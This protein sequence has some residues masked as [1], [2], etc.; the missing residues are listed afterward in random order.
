MRRREFITLLGGAAAAWPMA[1]RAQQPERMRRMGVFM[2]LASDD[3]D[4]QA[5]I[6][7]LL[8]GLQQYGWTIGGNLRVDYRWNVGD[9]DGFRRYAADLVAPAPDVI[10]TVAGAALAALQQATRII[11][12]VFVGAI[13]P[14]GAGVVASLARP[15]GNATGFTLYE[16]GLSGKWLELLKQFVP[17]ITRAGILRDSTTTGGVGQFAALQAVAPS[18]G[19]ELSP[20]DVRDA[21]EIERAVT[22]FAREP[23][24]ALVVTLSGLAISHRELIVILAARHR[25]PAVYAYRPF[26]TGGGLISYGP[27]I[28]DQYRRAAG[29][30]DRILKG[31]KP[32]DL[33]VQAPTKYELMINLKTAKALGLEIPPSLLAIADEV[34]E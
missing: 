27:D 4:A 20:L 32:A 17:R 26:V 5:R 10:V 33:P 15:G 1:A 25:M 19:V 2:N 7:A 3:P 23:N 11:P 16:F 28:V 14:V 13:D 9:V 30:V 22:A 31:E 18:F 34:I 24:S 21:G 8:Q 6:G 29:Y 12:I